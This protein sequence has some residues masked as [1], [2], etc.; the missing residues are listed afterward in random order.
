MEKRQC[1]EM[2]INDEMLD[3]VF[4]I[5]LVDKPAIEENVIK[6]SSEKIQLKVVDEERRIVGGFALVPEKKI[7]RRAEDGTEYDIKFSKETVQ[8]TAELFM[9]NQKGNEFTLEHEDNTDGVNIIESWIVEDAKNDKSNIYNLG[10]K[11]GEWC[12]M[13]KIDNQKFAD[14]YGRSQFENGDVM[15]SMVNE[16][17]TNDAI[18]FRTGLQ[19][20]LMRKVNAE[21]WQQRQMPIRTSGQY[22]GGGMSRK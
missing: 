21:K 17:F 9:K 13:S 14:C 4:A 20:S 11:G 16:A 15:R 19:N 8:L 6:L 12:L 1:I 10:A 5:S 7:L 22:M 3:G 2:I 18:E